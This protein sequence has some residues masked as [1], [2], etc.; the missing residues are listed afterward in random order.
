MQIG[1]RLNQLSFLEYQQIIENS[2]K[3]TDFN[4]LGLFR[5]LIENEYLDLAQKIEIR[6][7]AIGKFTKF[8]EFLQVK[9]AST[10]FDV[11][12]LHLEDMS[13]VE[14]AT[15][16]SNIK[17][18]QEKILKD[19]NIKHRNFGVYSKHICSEDWCPL[20]GLMLQKGSVLSNRCPMAFSTDKSKVMSKLKSKNNKK[21]RKN[22][23][24]NI[25]ELLKDTFE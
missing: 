25:Q 23:Q 16:W 5:S 1:K 6:D 18:N 12:T 15:F 13:P 7:L 24:Q 22:K 9:D 11:S 8:F 3:Y 20:N 4:T 10:Y 19:R 2:D 14:E 17:R 21:E